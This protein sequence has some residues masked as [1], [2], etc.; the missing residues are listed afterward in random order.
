MNDIRQAL[1]TI[2]GGS[3]TGVLAEII[4][5]AGSAPRKAGA[6]MLLSSDGTFSGTVGG[7]VLEYHAVEECRRLLHTGQ[8]TTHTYA[9]GPSGTGTDIGAICGGSAVVRF[10]PVD[11]AEA[12]R[13][14]AE[15]PPAPRVLLFGAGH[16]GKALADA[17]A[18]LGMDVTVTDDREALLTKSRF[19]H[20][21]TCL[22]AFDDVPVEASPHDLIVIMTHAHTHDYALLRRAMDT[23]AS[24]I[25]VMA[26]RA[27][28]AAF[29]QRLQ[30]EG[31]SAEEIGRRLRSP[32]GLP[33]RAE[34][35][36]EIAVSIAA[37]LIAELHAA[38]NRRSGQTAS[39]TGRQAERN[40]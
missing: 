11:A 37:E 10:R 17:L 6:R 23:P 3:G 20:A 22:H 39:L 34:T 33:I 18:L 26:S 2:A 12:A 16:V 4:E 29:R 30:Q 9:L 35:P 36:E 40:D 13:L 32:V 24:Y 15:L 28:A 5:T 21:S 7:G 31:F 8:E 1:E 25:G 38:Q 14:L 27:K 19:P